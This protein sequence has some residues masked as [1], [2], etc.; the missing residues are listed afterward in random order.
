MGQVLWLIPI[1]S[2]IW[3]V[4]IRRI[5]V[6]GQPRQKVLK[7]P[8]QP[9][10]A[11]HGGTHLS[12]QLCGNHKQEDCSPVWPMHKTR[13]Y[14]KNNQSKKGWGVTEE[15]LPS[16]CKALSSNP[17]TAKKNVVDEWT[18]EVLLNELC[19]PELHI[20]NHILDENY[21]YSLNNAT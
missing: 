19:L 14:L 17:S 16:K 6:Q 3:K 18:V 11:G 2:V 1:I 10:K 9:I 12:S 15:C 13:H 5:E 4:E 21:L 20:A 7:T 8:S